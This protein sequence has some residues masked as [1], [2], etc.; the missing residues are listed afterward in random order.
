MRPFRILAVTIAVLAMLVIAGCVRRPQQPP[1]PN[2]GALTQEFRQCT[3]DMRAAGVRFTPL[4]DRLGEDGCA[5]IG[6]VR[7]DDIGTPVANL[8]AM[9]CP[10]ARSFAAWVRY[11]VVPAARQH[12]GSEVVRI[13][14]YGTYACRNI[15]GAIGGPRSQHAFANAVDIAAFVLKDGRRVTLKDGWNGGDPAM[16]AFLR[17]VRASACRRFGVVLSPD[18][19][20]AHRDHFHFDMGRGPF[21]R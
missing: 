17:T 3:A 15:N 2:A 10:L 14:S 12:L 9:T 5:I 8:G 16:Q 6:S 19:N 11:G 4:P 13:E 20:D 1:V 21:C 18:Y 7:L